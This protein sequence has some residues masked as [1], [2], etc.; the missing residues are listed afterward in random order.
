MATW[1]ARAL[2]WG[3]VQVLAWGRAPLRQPSPGPAPRVVAAAFRE[4][5][6]GIGTGPV[7]SSVV[8]VLGAEGAL[9][10]AGPGGCRHSPSLPCLLLALTPRTL[11][12][13]A[14]LRW[15]PSMS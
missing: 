9:A 6:P 14:S 13:P 7:A 12:R 8:C 3:S 11:C 1:Q 15:E 2:A 4:A 5:P 10:L